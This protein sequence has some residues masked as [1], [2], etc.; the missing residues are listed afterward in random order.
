MDNKTYIDSICDS[1][2]YPV[3]LQTPNP[4]VSYLH[5][6]PVYV[7]SYERNGLI[8]TLRW[9][10]TH[11]NESKASNITRWIENFLYT[12]KYW[13]VREFVFP[14]DNIPLWTRLGQTEIKDF[15]CVDYFIP[16]LRLVIEVDMDDH[17]NKILDK[18]RDKFLKA[19]YGVSDVIRIGN[20]NELIPKIRDAISGYSRNQEPINFSVNN[21]NT[22]I[23]EYWEQ[24]WF[25]VEYE[26]IYGMP[27][28]PDPVFG[29]KHK[30]TYSEI[31]QIM[32]GLRPGYFK[33]PGPWEKITNK[34]G[35]L[36]DSDESKFTS[37]LIYVFEVLLGQR[38]S[39]LESK[40]T[41]NP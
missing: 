17:H 23:S 12:E 22:W 39:I 35:A 9:R 19:E 27:I 21:A 30:I 4:K 8:N 11:L 40:D 10:E 1:W 36:V 28:G 14:I 7:A 5:G 25:I 34:Y 33:K 6:F 18:A 29:G 15:V 38:L 13:Y 31:Y 2:I 41:S 37:K 26:K 24:L 3:L 32:S 20:E 16:T